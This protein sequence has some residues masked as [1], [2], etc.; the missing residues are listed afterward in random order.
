MDENPLLST[1]EV[2]ELTRVPAATL[3]WWRYNGEGPRSFHLGR[4]KVFYKRSDVLAW[5]EQQYGDQDG[6]QNA[7]V[8]R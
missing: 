2:A 5:I 8:A 4:R 6:E 7:G 3:R 1:A